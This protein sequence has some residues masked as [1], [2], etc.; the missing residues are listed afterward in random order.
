MILICGASGLVG[1]ELSQYFD[2]NNIEYLG[3]Y[4]KNKID[5]KN[6]FIKY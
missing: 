4:N 2:K 3:T 1:K 5:K 6:M